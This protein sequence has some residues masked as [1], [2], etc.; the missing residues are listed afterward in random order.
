MH[1][2]LTILLLSVALASVSAVLPTAVLAQG[3][4]DDQYADPFGDMPTDDQ[5]DG[6]GGGNDSAPTETG[7]AP[8]ET[9]EVTP[10][11]SGTPVAAEDTS[12]V[13]PTGDVDAA[14]APAEELPL[15][16]VP[17]GL[18]ALT[19]LVLLACGM[20]THFS[21]LRFAPNSAYA[22]ALRMGPLHQAPRPPGFEP[23]G[24]SRRIRRSRRM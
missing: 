10:E 21:L 19:G 5:P 4:G 22:R 8:P 23:L 9:G 12:G 14:A 18:L 6:G 24:S 1:R 13:V 11:P 15:T 16:G 2:S 17:A 3:A 20:L 7:S